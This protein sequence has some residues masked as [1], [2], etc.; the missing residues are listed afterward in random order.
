MLALFKV[1]VQQTS[2][3]GKWGPPSV[4]VT[5]SETQSHLCI[6]VESQLLSHYIGRVE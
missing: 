4:S 2:D 3:L 1:K 6:Y 5:F